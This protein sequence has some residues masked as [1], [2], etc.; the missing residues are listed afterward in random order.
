MRWRVRTDE[1]AHRIGLEPLDRE[2][3]GAAAWI[4]VGEAE[5]AV[6]ADGP[7]A[8]RAHVTG[9]ARLRG[10]RR[11]LL[12]KPTPAFDDEQRG[13]IAVGSRGGERDLGDAKPGLTEPLTHRVHDAD[14]DAVGAA[15]PVWRLRAR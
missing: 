12:G 3:V 7:G 14:A 8:D 4:G 1:H 9:A 11:A 15:Q 6:A 2:D 10:E 13:R 5:P